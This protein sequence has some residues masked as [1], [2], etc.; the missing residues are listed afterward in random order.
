ME[1]YRPLLSVPIVVNELR[2]CNKHQ[3]S[4]SKVGGPQINTANRK[5]AN[6]ADLINTCYL[7]TFRKCDTSRIC[8]CGPKLFG[9][10]ADLL[11]AIYGPMLFADSKPRPQIQYKYSFCRSLQICKLRINH[12]NL[13]I[14]DLRRGTHKIFVDFSIA[15]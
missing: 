14:C 1:N 12:E 13:Q 15:E 7:W 9:V 10:F 6:F 4:L 2:V 11:I 8:D 3:S 5:S